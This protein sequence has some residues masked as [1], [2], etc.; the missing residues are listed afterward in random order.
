MSER[1]D[2]S[3]QEKLERLKKRKRANTDTI[4]KWRWK[5][6]K[7]LSQENEKSLEIKE[8]TRNI[9]KDNK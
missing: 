5:K 4:K 9:I 2:L 8:N 1:M 3:N 7:L 6:F